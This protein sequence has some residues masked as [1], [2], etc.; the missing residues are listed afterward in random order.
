MN[1]IGILSDTHG[2][3]HP[4]VADF[5]TGMDEIWHAGDIGD[6]GVVERLK[7]VATLRAVHGNIDG[8]PLRNAIPGVQCFELAGVK[9]LMTHIGGYPG[10]YDPAARQLIELHRP[11]LFV[12]GH[13]HILR[14]IYDPKHELLHINPGAAGKYGIHKSVTAVRLILEDG[15]MRDLEVLDLP[16]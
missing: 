12:C 6:Q 4:R 2:Y 14:V 15:N 3:V 10:R 1:R 8:Q 11:K 16:R 9:V 7:T 5:F 13:S